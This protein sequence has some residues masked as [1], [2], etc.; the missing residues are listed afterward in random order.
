MGWI[1]GEL[2]RGASSSG[3]ECGGA[4]SSLAA[5]GGGSSGAS[6]VVAVLFQAFSAMKL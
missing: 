5:D 2:L 6:I 4:S 1:R 3:A